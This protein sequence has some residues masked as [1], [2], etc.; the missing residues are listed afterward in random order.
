MI[1]Y[2]P[3]E[4]IESRY[5]THLDRDIISYL[6][7]SNLNYRRIHGLGFKRSP[8]PPSGCFLNY[9]YTIKFKM[10]QLQEIA[11]LFEDGLVSDGDVFWFSDLWF[12]GIESIAYMNY[13]AKKKI[14]IKGVIHA[15]SW[16][17]TDFVRGMERWA[18]CFEDCLFDL[19]DEVYVGTNFS[20]QQLIERRLIDPSKVVVTG[21]PIDSKLPN[22]LPPKEDIVV[23]NGRLCDEKQPHLFDLLK[24]RVSPL[25][26]DAKFVKTMELG[27]NREDYIDLLGRAKVCVSYALQENFGYGLIEAAL[28]GC[29]PV[30]PDRLSYK[31][32]FKDIFRYSTFKE[33]VD[34]TVNALRGDVP[35]TRPKIS[36]NNTIFKRWFL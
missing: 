35:S 26:P 31:E 33:S 7:S 3:L 14:K 2:V 32:I 15:G 17:D 29:V 21:L 19:V 13:F 34:M 16:T 28:Q 30:V 11:K 10:A 5:T 18:K 24:E 23:F 22:D 20:A 25:F 4:R 27:L 1:F 36:S 8:A 6:E 12:P 9:S